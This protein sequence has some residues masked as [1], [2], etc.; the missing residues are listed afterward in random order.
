M[1]NLPPFSIYLILLPNLAHTFDEEKKFLKNTKTDKKRRIYAFSFSFS[2]DFSETLSK[3]TH[4]IYAILA[5]SVCL[6]PS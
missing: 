1:S 5:E 4:S 3:S 6:E 2:E